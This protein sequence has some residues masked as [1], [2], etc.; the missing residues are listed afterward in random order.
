MAYKLFKKG[1][2]DGV[3]IL[4]SGKDGIPQK[5]ISNFIHIGMKYNIN[6]FNLYNILK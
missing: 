3:I 6:L 2:I 4:D 1:V 5:L